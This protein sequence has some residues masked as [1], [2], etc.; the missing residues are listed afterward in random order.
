M[1]KLLTIGIGL[2]LIWVVWFA[3]GYGIYIGEKVVIYTSKIIEDP[4]P[5]TEPKTD[6][7]KIIDKWRE[8]AG[9]VEEMAAPVTYCRYL[10]AIGIEEFQHP[11]SICPRRL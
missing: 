7:D 4:P 8:E 11:G 6:V 5:S 2:A 1:K 10:T 3:S 9:E